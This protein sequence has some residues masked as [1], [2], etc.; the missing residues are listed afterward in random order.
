MVLPTPGVGYA[1]GRSGDNRDLQNVS[2]KHCTLNSK[3]PAVCHT[4]QL[5][6]GYCHNF[7]LNYPLFLYFLYFTLQVIRGRGTDWRGT[8]TIIP[9]WLASE[10]TGPAGASLMTHLVS[11]F[12]TTPALVGFTGS[13]TV[14]VS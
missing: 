14:Q 5:N 12:K 4:G 1:G 7:L 10:T 8:V 13:S 9:T 2:I 6:P 3:S 11:I